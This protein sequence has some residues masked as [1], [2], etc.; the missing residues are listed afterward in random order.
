LLPNRRDSRL[1]GLADDEGSALTMEVWQMAETSPA[2]FEIAMHSNML[3]VWDNIASLHDNPAFPR[4]QE[5][6]TWFFNIVNPRGIE[7]LTS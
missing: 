2:R 3:I 7:P 1:E 4:N 5:R 6:S